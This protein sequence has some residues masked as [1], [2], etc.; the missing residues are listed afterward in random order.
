MAYLDIAKQ[1]EA[2]RTGYERNDINEP[3]PGVPPAPSDRGVGEA[4]RWEALL[5]KAAR[6]PD[7]R[8]GCGARANHLTRAGI[9]QCD[10]CAGIPEPGP[11]PMGPALAEACAVYERLRGELLDMT[12]GL[13]RARDARDAAEVA[14]LETALSP[15]RRQYSEAGAVVAAMT[16]IVEGRV[17]IEP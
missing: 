8:C 17:P 5:A 12:G 13:I 2:E 7:A 14:R 6:E 11:E 15:V 3:I 1:A 10:P 9:W 16:G 4:R